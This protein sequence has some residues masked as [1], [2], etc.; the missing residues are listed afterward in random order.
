MWIFCGKSINIWQGDKACVNFQVENPAMYPYVVLIILYKLWNYL[1]LL[2]MKVSSVMFFLKKK[3]WIYPNSY[4]RKLHSIAF[5][6][7]LWI[8]RSALA[9]NVEGKVKWTL[10][11]KSVAG[12]ELVCNDSLSKFWCLH[13]ENFILLTF[14]DRTVHQIIL[15]SFKFME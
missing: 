15:Q 7:C 12:T 1:W 4:V 14:I 10:I 3:K 11:S 8:R 5:F 9:F 6:Q 13:C 2:A